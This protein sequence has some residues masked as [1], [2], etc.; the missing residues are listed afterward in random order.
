MSE[1]NTENEST[2]NSYTYNGLKV[3]LEGQGYECF[4]DYAANH[5]HQQKTL[6][7]ELVAALLETA[8]PDELE[9]WLDYSQ[10][11]AERKRKQSELEREAG[12]LTAAL[13]R[14]KEKEEQLQAAM[15]ALGQ[16]SRPKI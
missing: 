10:A 8:T 7:Q 6:M 11:V 12:R 1:N 3:V 13:R 14:H 5:G 16:V 9:K 15:A 4:R 2:R